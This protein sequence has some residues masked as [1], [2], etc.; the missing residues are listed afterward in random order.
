M[1]DLDLTA[2]DVKKE[3]K[4]E[5]ARRGMVVTDADPDEEPPEPEGH[6]LTPKVAD[7][8]AKGQE[9]FHGP[10]P[11]DIAAIWSHPP[12][13]VADEATAR[14]LVAV[15]GMEGFRG[16]ALHQTALA[17]VARRVNSQEVTARFKSEREK[18]KKR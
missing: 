13:R 1:D 6:R 8:I 17:E 15:W 4:A 12:H 16:S 7:W 9:F 14:I 3:I 11:A 5:A 18:K 2:E 10:L